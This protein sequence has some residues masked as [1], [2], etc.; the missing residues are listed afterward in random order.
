[1]RGIDVASV[2]GP[3]QLVVGDLSFISLRTIMDDLVNLMED[4]GQMVML[5]KPQFEAA[6]EDVGDGG[7]IQSAQVQVDVIESV[8]SCAMQKG[9]VILGLTY[10]P[11]KGPKGNIEFLLW[12]AKAT[13]DKN[14][15]ER[16]SPY[17]VRAVVESARATLGGRL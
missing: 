9:L 3:F 5:I 6:R 11:I 2:E 4:D 10:S 12:A 17:S 13:C 7:V 14:L 1:M 16:K 8:I 15:M